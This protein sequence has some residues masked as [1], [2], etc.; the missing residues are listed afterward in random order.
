MAVIGNL[1]NLITFEVSSDKVQTFS[2]LR[3]SVSA[4]WAKHDIIGHT[5][6]LEFLGIETGE[7]TLDIKLI[8]SPYINPWK[9]LH[10][11]RKSV[12]NGTPHKF[13]L[14]GTKV[15]GSKQWVITNLSETWDAV[16]S[17]GKLVSAK[18]T[19]TIKAYY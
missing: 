4:R 8:A 17:D 10:N 6:K 7:I 16:I 2:N 5:P 1:G 9:V 12:H 11:I 3:R 19:I 18:A 15:G 13:V 14:G